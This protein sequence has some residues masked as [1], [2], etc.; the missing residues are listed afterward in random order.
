VLLDHVDGKPLRKI[1]D[2]DKISKSKVEREFRRELAK[3]PHNNDFTKKY[4]NRF[5]GIIVVDGKYVKVRNYDSKIPLLWGIDYLSHDVPVFK[6][7]PSESY[8]SW[9]KY[10]GYLKTIKYP[11]KIIVC[12]DN[13]NI[14]RA[15]K[16]IFPRALIQ[17]CHNH[18]LENIRKALRTR[19]EKEYIPFV[20]DLKKELFSLKLT[21]KTFRKRSFKLFN[22][23]QNDDTCVRCLLKINELTKELTAAHYVKKTPRDTNLIELYNSHLEARLKSIKGF[24]SFA[25]AE[26]WLNAYILRRR[27]KAFTDCSKKFRYLN[28]KTAVSVTSKKQAVLPVLFV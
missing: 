11:L 14:R 7:A 13:E 23:Y 24:K 20:E 9:L 27:L 10:F 22:K 25:G 17:L 8:Q 21:V 1:A 5:C 4:C 18:Y 12:D 6:L 28:G 16:Y 2:K 19:T 15:A 26:Q 3:L